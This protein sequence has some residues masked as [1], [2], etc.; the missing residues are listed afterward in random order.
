MSGN[1]QNRDQ[2]AAPSLRKMERALTIL[3]IVGAAIYW[4]QWIRHIHQCWSLMSDSSRLYG[5]L[6]LVIYPLPAAHIFASRRYPSPPMAALF[7]YL[8][9]SFA[10]MISF[11]GASPK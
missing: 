6:L 5:V 4:L 8:L 9:I 2:Q 1:M 10:L 7:A 3:V 11:P